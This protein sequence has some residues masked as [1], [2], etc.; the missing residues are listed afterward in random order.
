V[1]EIKKEELLI[2]FE[3]LLR[4]YPELSYDEVVTL[5]DEVYSNKS[6]S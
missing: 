6:E 4:K 1:G 3:H 2:E 5:L